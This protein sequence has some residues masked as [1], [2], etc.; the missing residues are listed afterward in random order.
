[1]MKGCIIGIAKYYNM[2]SSSS[3]RRRLTG[4]DTCATKFVARNDD[5]FVPVHKRVSPYDYGHAEMKNEVELKV[6]NTD[7]ALDMGMT[8]MTTGEI[9]VNGSKLIVNWDNRRYGGRGMMC[10]NAISYVSNGSRMSNNEMLTSFTGYSAK[11]ALYT[12]NSNDRLKYAAALNWASNREL[13]PIWT[14]YLSIVDTYKEDDASRMKMIGQAYAMSEGTMIILE[15]EDAIVVSRFIHG[16]SMLY[17]SIRSINVGSSIVKLDKVEHN[18]EELIKCMRDRNMYSYW[19]R[20]WTMQELHLSNEAEYFMLYED[21]VRKPDDIGGDWAYGTYGDMYS[22]DKDPGGAFRKMAAIRNIAKSSELRDASVITYCAMKKII[23][24]TM[25]R[26]E[27]LFEKVKHMSSN[28]MGE[29]VMKEAEL[30]VYGAKTGYNEGKERI[31]SQFSSLD[32]SRSALNTLE[33][34][35]KETM[36]QICRLLTGDQRLEV[37]HVVDPLEYN[38]RNSCVMY[39]LCNNVRC[40]GSEKDMTLAV[41]IALGIYGGTHEERLSSIDARFVDEGFLPFVHQCGISGSNTTWRPRELALASNTGKSPHKSTR[42][43]AYN[44]RTLGSRLFAA[45]GVDNELIIKGTEFKIKIMH[46]VVPNKDNDIDKLCDGVYIG[47]EQDKHIYNVEVMIDDT[48]PRNSYLADSGRAIK[49]VLVYEG[50][51]P[52]K[53]KI[54]VIHSGEFMMIVHKNYLTA[55]G[56]LRILEDKD[57]YMLELY[58]REVTEESRMYVIMTDDEKWGTSANE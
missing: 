44:R 51:L 10:F 20:A 27:R 25:E 24:S 30:K 21:E 6:P 45:V 4:Y 39:D 23:K 18:V 43:L 17:S 41:A 31:M 57:R 36:W 49:A 38:S 47:R 11:E 53:Y 52:E 14:D 22:K 37:V 58:D 55:V 32:A 35:A 8:D 29:R 34:K 12:R 15:K 3:V 54:N 56:T 5:G 19:S 2:G 28:G 16:L 48:V 13:L 9:I 7:G 1:M 26:E 40:A 46:K 42:Y 50:E 33:R